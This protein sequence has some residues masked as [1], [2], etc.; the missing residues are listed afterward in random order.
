MLILPSDLESKA[1]LAR[2]LANSVEDGTLAQLA[3]RLNYLHHYQDDEGT[4]HRCRVHIF[5]SH[6]SQYIDIYWKK[7]TRGEDGLPTETWET[8]MNGGLVCHSDGDW[9]IHT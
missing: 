4:G 6:K 7:R 8:W 2:I 1:A 9:S 5:P 3:N